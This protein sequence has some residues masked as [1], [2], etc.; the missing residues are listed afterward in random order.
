MDP[1]ELLKNLQSQMSGMQEQLKDITAKG[2][3]GGGM[4]TVELNGKMEVLSVTIAKEVVD[5]ED[6]SMLEDLVLAAFNSA[7]SSIQGKIA[8]QA[9]SLAGGAGI[10]GLG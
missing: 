9:S 8:Q 10:P 2:S 1:M 3:S 5:P 6:V 4:V 7:V